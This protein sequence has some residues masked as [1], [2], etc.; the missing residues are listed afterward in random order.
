MD[1]QEQLE[2]LEE[3]QHKYDALK[4]KTHGERLNKTVKLDLEIS[5]K[6]REYSKLLK[7]NQLLEAK[8]SNT[9]TIKQQDEW[10]QLTDILDGR[11]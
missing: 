8:I 3:L 11:V 7:E 1:N 6:E 4:E 10:K 2:L 9:E 5:D